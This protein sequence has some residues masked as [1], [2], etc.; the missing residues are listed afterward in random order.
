MSLVFT[1]TL[2]GSYFEVDQPAITRLCEVFIHV[3]LPRPTGAM[4]VVEAEMTGTA[5]FERL[6]T[7]QP[8]RGQLRLQLARP[9]HVSYAF[10]VQTDDGRTLQF[11]GAKHPSLMRPVYSATSLWGTLSEAGVPRAMVRLHFDL[12]RDLVAFLQSLGRTAD[13]LP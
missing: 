9:R 5:T 1:E 13:R 10:Q 8:I 6:A 3:R 2:R 4:R 7:Q 12:R 11:A